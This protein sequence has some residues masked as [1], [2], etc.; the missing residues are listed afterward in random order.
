MPSSKHNR[1]KDRSVTNLR[2]YSAKDDPDRWWS[3]DHEGLLDTPQGW[4]FL[5]SGDAF[6][7]RRVKAL[8]PHWTVLRKRKGYTTTLGLLAPSENIETATRI[9]H[10]TIVKR[11]AERAVASRYRKVR[12][13]RYSKELE[14]AILEYLDFAPEHKALGARIAKEAT[15]RA[16]EVGTGRVGRTRLLTIHEKARLAARAHIRH[17]HT[18]YERRLERASTGRNWVTDEGLDREEGPLD[19]DGLSFEIDEETHREI[20]G[21]AEDEVDEFLKVHQDS[22]DN[23]E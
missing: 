22:L 17:N 8:G 3:P 4:L 1:S 16:A 5:P 2:V 12:E 13:I 19:G 7:T 21:L 6:I 20:K 11:M 15:S 23:E 14:K 9:S 18:T 10:E